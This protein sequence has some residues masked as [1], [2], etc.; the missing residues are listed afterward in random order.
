MTGKQIDVVSTNT[1]TVTFAPG[2]GVSIGSVDS[3]LTIAGTYHAVTLL[4][5]DTNSW[6]IIG[7][8]A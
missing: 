1:G 8:L 5:L 3:S 4:K 6:V 7:S 2:S